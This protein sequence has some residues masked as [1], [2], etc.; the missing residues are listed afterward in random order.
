[1][2]ITVLLFASLNGPRGHHPFAGHSRLPQYLWGMAWEWIL[3]A[4][5]WLGIR[6]RTSLRA[7]IGGRWANMEE[8]LRDLL[9]AA[10]FWVCALSV[11]GLG[12]R[13]IASRSGRKD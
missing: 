12:A 9:Y 13:L 5:T 11:L 7:L 3:L 8:F 1:M 4:F 6:K 2:L 10:S